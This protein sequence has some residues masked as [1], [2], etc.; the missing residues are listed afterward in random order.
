MLGDILGTLSQVLEAESHYS[1]PEIIRNLGDNPQL[2]PEV[3]F[4]WKI[5]RVFTGTVLGV[6]GG[7]TM[8]LL[9]KGFGNYEGRSF[10]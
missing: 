3:P 7:F 6:S 8:R 4:S 1:N 9:A 2:W 10:L 5:D